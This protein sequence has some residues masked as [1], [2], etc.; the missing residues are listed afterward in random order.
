MD[1]QDTVWYLITLNIIKI[2]LNYRCKFY[3][4]QWDIF[5]NRG[6][7]ISGMSH[8]DSLRTSSV[9]EPNGQVRVVRETSILE[10]HT[11]DSYII[12]IGVYMNITS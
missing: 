8:F 3:Q 9:K 1:R 5:K 12:E 2:T 10:D 11:S 4:K 6:N 7:K